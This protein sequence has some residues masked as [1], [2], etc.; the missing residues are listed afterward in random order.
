MIKILIQNFK[1]LSQD[2]LNATTRTL[3]Q[4]DITFACITETWQYDQYEEHEEYVVATSVPTP[5]LRN[6][7]RRSGGLAILAQPADKDN[8]LVLKRTT[9]SIHFLYK[10]TSIHLV[11]LPPYLPWSDCL[12]FLPSRPVTLL[13]GDLNCGLHAR[14]SQLLNTRRDHLATLCQQ[15]QLN[16]TSDHKKFRTDQVLTAFSYHSQVAEHKTLSTKTDHIPL[17]VTMIKPES[18]P[19]TVTTR[20]NLKYL[21]HPVTRLLLCQAF[22]ALWVESAMLFASLGARIQATPDPQPILN[23]YYDLY[24]GLIESICDQVIGSYVVHDQQKRSDYLPTFLSNNLTSAHAIRLFKRSQRSSIKLM[25]SDHPDKDPLTDGTEFYSN[26]YNPSSTSF[27]SSEYVRQPKPTSSNTFLSFLDTTTIS[28]AIYKYPTTKSFGLDTMHVKILQALCPSK[29]FLPSIHSFFALCAST[30]VTPSQWN[31]SQ[32]TPIPKKSDTFTPSSSRPISLTPCFR[33]IFESTILSFVYTI[34]SLCTFSPFQAGFRKGFNTTTH[35]WASQ[36]ANRLPSSPKNLSIFLDLEKAYDRVPI[37]RLLDKLL[38]KDTPPSI[39][40]LIDSLFSKCHSQLIVNKQV[41]PTFFR[42]RGLFQG[43]ILS[44]WLFN[45]YIDDLAHSIARLD[46]HPFL[47]PCLLFAD[48]IMLLPSSPVIARRMLAVVATWSVRNGISINLPKCGVILPPTSSPLTLSLWDKPLPVVQEYTYLGMPFTASGIDFKAHLSSLY[49]STLKLFFASS[50]N[51][52]SWTPLLRLA[53]F[54]IFYRSKYEYASPLLLAHN[55][56]LARLQKLQD[57]LLKWINYGH[58]GSSINHAMTGIP[59]VAQRLQELEMRFQSSLRYLHKDNPLRPLMEQLRSIPNPSIT[60]QKQLLYTLLHRP[61]MLQKY[62]Q[63]IARIPPWI[64]Y[65]FS[66]FILKERITFFGNDP[67]ILP[68]LILPYARNSS[69][70]D[71][72]LRLRSAQLR[73]YALRW[74]KNRLAANYKCICGD[75]LTRGHI[76]SC[77]DLTNNPIVRSMEPPFP[78]SPPVAS[79]NPI[80]HALNVGDINAFRELLLFVTHHDDFAKRITPRSRGRHPR[81]PP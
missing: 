16:W 15:L 80:D 33:R 43:S 13:I 81:K 39:I 24:V 26:L 38:R 47:P 32:I 72:S 12:P 76:S 75:K 1:G 34:P 23:I 63:E 66:E 53:M 54:K 74:R 51:S 25:Q 20:Y 27:F 71:I 44:P 4:N 42:S 37:P 57:M 67:L 77:Y 41:G 52:R 58:A 59:P 30:T 11:Y 21:D 48:D 28:R 31:I 61:P 73:S 69:L 56:P 14:Q 22:D 19:P 9:H 35:L 70:V 68:R 64:P 65:S 7:H 49:S 10:S 2:K 45:V 8:F 6:T 5:K 18:S 60:I 78:T 79:Y 40:Q 55:I 62:D 29:H 36:I 17:L 50:K 46:P 3:L